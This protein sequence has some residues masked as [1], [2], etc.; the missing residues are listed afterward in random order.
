MVTLSQEIFLT[1][2][3]AF[4]CLADLGFCHT[5]TKK[6]FG[7]TPKIFAMPYRPPEML[8]RLPY[9]QSADMWA[10]G[11]M[12]YFYL[13]G[14]HLFIAGSTKET[15][16]LI[17]SEVGLKMNNPDIQ[18]KEGVSFVPTHKIKDLRGL[19]RNAENQDLVTNLID[20]MKQLLVAEPSNRLTAEQALAHPTFE[21]P[22]ITTESA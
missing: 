18:V 5:V 8:L 3:Q 15:I 13:T 14:K 10:V 21:I 16:L 11:C 1:T 4:N 22:A 20:I 19:Y 9:D 17:H 12:F 7:E 2:L 6:Y